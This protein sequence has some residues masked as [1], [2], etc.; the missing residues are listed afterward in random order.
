M[1]AKKMKKRLAQAKR[2]ARF[3]LRRDHRWAEA[4]R[5]VGMWQG[6]LAELIEAQRVSGK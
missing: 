4:F 2:A 6:R 3:T 1:T 5:Q